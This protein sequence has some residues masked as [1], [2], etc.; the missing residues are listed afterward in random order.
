MAAAAGVGVGVD[1]GVDVGGGIKNLFCKIKKN[2]VFSIDRKT[3]KTL[4]QMVKKT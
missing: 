3:S 2:L 1:I 4:V